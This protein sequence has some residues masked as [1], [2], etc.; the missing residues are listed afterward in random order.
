MAESPSPVTENRVYIGCDPG[1]TGAIVALFPDGS[2][3]VYDVPLSAS[4][5]GGSVID[6]AATWALAQFLSSFG[7]CTFCIEHTWGVR[8]QGGS[9][10][11]KFGDTAGSLRAMF[12]AAGCRVVRAS[13]QRWTAALRVGSDKARHVAAA[14][15]LFPA[16][17]REFTPARGRITLAQCEGRAD[18]TLIAEYAR[19]NGL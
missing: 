11:Y 17:A 14:C 13:S 5:V 18:A 12:V 16:H 3:A 8:G 10:Q 15:D 4:P 7:P 2:L 1:S 9:S 19:R 6:D